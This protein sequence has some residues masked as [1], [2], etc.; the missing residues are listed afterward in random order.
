MPRKPGKAGEVVVEPV[1]YEDG[2]DWRIV[3][4]RPLG[5]DCLPLFAYGSMKAL[6]SGAVMHVHPDMVEVCAFM[7]G[8]VRYES[9]GSSYHILPGHVFMSRPDEPHRRTSNPKG[10][11]LYRMLFGI[12]PPGGTI[13]GLS[14]EETALIVKAIVKA[15]VRL[16]HSTDRLNAAFARVYALLPAMR[17]GK[18]RGKAVAG[19]RLRDRLEMRCAALELMLALSEAPLAPHV[20]KW[21][22][23]AKVKELAKRIEENPG[24]DYPVAALAAESSLSPFAF[25]EAFKRE[26]GLTPHAYLMLNRVKRAYEDLV[27]GRKSIS[28]VSDKWGFS[29]PQHMA[30]AFRRY[31]G[32][33]PSKVLR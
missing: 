30:T 23:N 21:R 12:P 27:D 17:G 8:D 16:F 24:A 10:M 3:D 26:T 19:P 9:E 5:A 4:L 28:F 14:P 31:L 7:K 18:D 11:V 33:T 15:P 29:S 13:L 6:R 1:F 25:T 20:V 2:D 32:I 22:P